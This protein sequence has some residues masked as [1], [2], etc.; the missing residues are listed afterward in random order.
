[1]GALGL[2]LNMVVLWITIYMEVVLNQL[3]AEGY[4][5]RDE[6][7]SRFSPLIHLHINM[8]ELEEFVA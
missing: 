5:M 6:D 3:H 4:P 2:V 8:M 7:V 1:L